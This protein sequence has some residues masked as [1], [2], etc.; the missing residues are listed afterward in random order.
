MRFD[1]YEAR[2]YDLPIE[3]RYDRLW[4]RYLSPEL[5]SLAGLLGAIPL[6]LPKL[7]EERLRVLSALGVAD[8]MQ[9]A[10]DRK[11]DVPGLRVAYSG[12]DARVYSSY[13]ALPRAWVVGRQRVVAGEDAALDAFGDPD[14]RPAEEAIV[15]HRIDGVDGVGGDA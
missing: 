5:P 2:G 8:V 4:R 11:L 7:D 13:R 6:S 3:R 14:W 15:E 9:A 12:P 1:L 10:G